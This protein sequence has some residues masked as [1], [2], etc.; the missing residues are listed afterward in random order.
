MRNLILA[1]LIGATL[2]P[3]AAMAQNHDRRDARVERRDHDDSYRSGNRRDFRDGRG[4]IRDA[5]NR[6]GDDRR[7]YRH[8]RNW[9]NNDWR[10]YRQ[11]NRDLYR[12]GNWNSDFRYRAFRPGVIIGGGFY[13]P[14]YYINDYSRF[15]LANPGFNRRW[16]RHY[17]DVL[18]VNVRTGRVITVHRNFYR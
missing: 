5:R 16:V 6:I 18:L 15:R 8:D 4:D 11:T 2:V 9:G 7:D 10:R 1:A 3:G 12:G 17:N 13:Q 14:R